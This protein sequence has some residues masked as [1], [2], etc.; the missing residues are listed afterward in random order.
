[1]SIHFGSFRPFP[2]V[3]CS[4]QSSCRRAKFLPPQL[5][6]RRRS[7]AVKVPTMSHL[8]VAAVASAQLPSVEKAAH[9]L[10]VLTSS[11]LCCSQVE[12]PSFLNEHTVAY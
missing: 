8:A 5:G 10:I 3:H 9:V 1:M 2:L 11:S 12:V 7:I 4:E 6:G